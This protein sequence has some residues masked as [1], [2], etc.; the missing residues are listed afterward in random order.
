MRSRS[1][2]TSRSASPTRRAAPRF[3]RSDRSPRSSTSLVDLEAGGRGDP[4]DGPRLKI[5]NDPI[6]RTIGPTRLTHPEVSL[7]A[8]PH[9]P[10]PNLR[11]GRRQPID[12]GAD[13]GAAASR[14]PAS[15]TANTSGHMPRL[16]MA[17]P[18]A[19]VVG[20]VRG[21]GLKIMGG[22]AERNRAG[23]RACA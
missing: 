22:P 16:L 17:P 3:R 11:V 15:A 7:R 12:G 9:V 2:S 13:E 14:A 20:S 6:D 5:V 19:V 8:D 10:V 18:W 1:G 21:A 4:A 23:G